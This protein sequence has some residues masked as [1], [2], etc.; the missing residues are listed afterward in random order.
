MVV[1]ELDRL[2]I[3]VAGLQETRWFD[4]EIYSVADS[5]VLSSG[6][7]L[8]G[9]GEVLSRGEGVAIVLRGRALRAW[10]GGGSQWRAISFRLVAQLRMSSWRK[11]PFVMHIICCYV[12]IFWSSRAVKDSFF[13]DLQ[14]ILRQLDRNH[15]LCC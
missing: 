3:E 10:K 13:Q 8:P 14:D 11:T 9:D 5:V 1:A 6:R 2:G 12:P 15:C 4:R 7:P